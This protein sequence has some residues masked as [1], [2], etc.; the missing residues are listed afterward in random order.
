MDDS[1]EFPI[2]NVITPLR[3][4]QCMGV[5]T[6]R[7]WETGGSA[8]EEDGAEGKLGDI[9]FHLEW[10]IVIWAIKSHVAFDQADEV[11]YS[12]VLLVSLTERDVLL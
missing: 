3:W 11:F 2:V 6:N 8:L 10:A 1:K 12:C 7:A 9:H 4:G 5:V